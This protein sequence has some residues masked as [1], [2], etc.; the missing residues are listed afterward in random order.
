M[1]R[2]TKKKNNSVLVDPHTHTPSSSK[3]LQKI[4]KL[5]N[6]EG[7]SLQLGCSDSKDISRDGRFVS[8]TNFMMPTPSQESEI[9]DFKC[10]VLEALSG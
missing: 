4:T 10:A 7:F 3:E 6:T 5:Q 8:K 1:E 2:K 9:I